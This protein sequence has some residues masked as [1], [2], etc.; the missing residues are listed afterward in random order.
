MPESGSSRAASAIEP[1]RR[2]AGI[3]IGR[4]PPKR[5]P[6]V[7]TRVSSVAITPLFPRHQ[8]V[9]DL[10]QE[11]LGRGGRRRRRRIPTTEGIGG[12]HQHEQNP[13][14]NQEVNQN[15]QKRSIG[16]NGALLL[17]I[18]EIGSGHRR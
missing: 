16:Q 12:L 10:H 5:N 17:V 3:P 14:Y 9:S 8:R 15:R 13:S 2:S 6:G 11:S 18:G 7:H 4:P 1:S